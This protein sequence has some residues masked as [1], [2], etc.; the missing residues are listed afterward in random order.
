M[1]GRGSSDRGRGGPMR[2]MNSMMR[3]R[4]GP[5]RGGP[6]RGRFVVKILLFY[7]TFLLVTLFDSSITNVCTK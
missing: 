6:M 7:F 1:R 2:G 5:G 3:G 4:G